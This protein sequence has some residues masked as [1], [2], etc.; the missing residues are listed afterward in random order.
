MF[1]F[2]KKKRK[3]EKDIF[4]VGEFNMENINLS[5]SYNFIT[6]FRYMND[7]VNT[8][9]PACASCYGIPKNKNTEYEQ[10]LE[11]IGRR[12]KS[13][14]TSILEHSNVVLQVYIPLEGGIEK[15]TTKHTN[16]EDILDISESAYILPMISE[17][18]DACRYLTLYTDYIEDGNIM[19][20]TIGGSIR[21][22]RYI[23]ENIQNRE[24]RL[25][26]SIFKVLTTVIP[27]QF[28]IDFIN[29]E[30]MS[31]Y[32]HME[33]QSYNKTINSDLIDIIN[34]DDLVKISDKLKIGDFN[35]LD[36]V[37]ITVNFKN[38]SRVI[39]QQVTR[40]RNAITQES[41]RYVNYSDSCF[42]SPSKF[43]DKYD[44]YTVYHTSL[45]DYNLQGLGDLLTNL[46][47]D[48]VKQGVEKED[49]RGYLPQNVQCGSLYMTFTLR[50]LL[51]FLQLRTDPH[52][53]AEVRM[54]ANKLAELTDSYGKNLGY[55]NI[56]KAAEDLTKPIYARSYI[57][58]YSTIDEEV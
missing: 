16:N 23:F 54:Y 38:M 33:T 29:D 32:S 44:E 43:K 39:T 24:N 46:Y 19:R 17:V 35:C 3:P 34:V 5:K 50:T 22:Y 20:L 2:L 21:G 51:S 14:H 15:V 56:L 31:S 37:S 8:V 4:K 30:V 10:R 6:V 57:D 55:D 36:F 49:A 13:Y 40:H 42:N 41:Q 26:I 48:L 47:S 12:V 9:Y 45:G 1:N 25:F 52:A 58:P 11:Y 28:F 18:R 53:Q 7:V 27:K